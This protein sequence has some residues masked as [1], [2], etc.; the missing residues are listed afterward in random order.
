MGRISSAIDERK[1]ESVVVGRDKGERRSA[2][3]AAPH[4]LFV[5]SLFRSD[6]RRLRVRFIAAT[7]LSSS[8]EAAEAEAVLPSFLICAVKF[9]GYDD[10]GDGGGGDDQA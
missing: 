9:P 7:S 6:R 1:W 3:I 5:R 10:D 8:F 4:L 2:L